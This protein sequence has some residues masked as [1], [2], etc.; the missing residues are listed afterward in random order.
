MQEDPARSM[1][2]AA[3]PESSDA[4]DIPGNYSHLINAHFRSCQSRNSPVQPFFVLSASSAAPYI[5]SDR[6]R[7]EKR[8]YGWGCA[9]GG[10]VC[11]WY[12]RVG[13]S[14]AVELLQ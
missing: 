8:A 2:H 13:F 11:V 14:K 10:G 3:G 6:F 4:I 12:P 5:A 1:A 7:L 9:L